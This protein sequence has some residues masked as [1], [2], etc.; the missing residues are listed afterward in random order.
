MK[1]LIFNFAVVGAL[2]Y[3]FTAENGW[4]NPADDQRQE[5]YQELR[6]ELK[7]LARKVSEGLERVAAEPEPQP[8]AAPAPVPEAKAVKKPVR[9]P[10]EVVKAA[11]AP[12][13]PK[14]QEAQPVAAA[15][16]QTAKPAGAG[17]T[18]TKPAESTAAASN[19]LPAVADPAVAARRAEVLEGVGFEDVPAESLAAA[20]PTAQ[21][22]PPMSPDERLRSL[23]SLAEE[24][25][26]LYVRKLA[27]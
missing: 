19:N 6:Q 16:S 5:E 23:Y 21:A 11:R 10:A 8:A 26:L 14:R 24:M 7:S 17:E 4:L 20:D 3:L 22:G 2:F 15:A 27:R 18:R 25:E 1:F 9:K 13:E 12:A